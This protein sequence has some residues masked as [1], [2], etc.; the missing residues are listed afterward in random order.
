MPK[1][2]LEEFQTSHLQAGNGVIY[3]KKPFKI[4]LEESRSKFHK[5]GDYINP[6]HP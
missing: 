3:D 6:S 5:W 2:L 1:N 4:R